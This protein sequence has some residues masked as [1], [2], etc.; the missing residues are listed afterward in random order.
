MISFH[1]DIIERKDGTLVSYHTDRM[2]KRI[3]KWTRTTAD[4]FIRKPSRQDYESG[5]HEWLY[6]SQ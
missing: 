1:A 5:Y 6:K 2:K 3:L 4:A